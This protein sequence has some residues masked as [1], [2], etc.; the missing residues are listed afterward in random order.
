MSYGLTDGSATTL[1]ACRLSSPIRGRIGRL[2]RP[3]GQTCRRL[4]RRHTLS[5]ASSGPPRQ[6]RSA[7]QSRHRRPSA[8][9][10]R[11][12]PSQLGVRLR[13]T[14]RW[15][16]CYAGLADPVLRAD[17]ARA[18]HFA[19]LGE[20]AA[21]RQQVR[22]AVSAVRLPGSND[23]ALIATLVRCGGATARLGHIDSIGIESRPGDQWCLS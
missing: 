15:P 14:R 18:E 12:A 7:R 13:S 22:E 3:N 19:V 21:Q 20:V 8:Q 1:H 4:R 2:W 9:K 16:V 11:F 23:V 5:R 6:Q 10:P 17:S